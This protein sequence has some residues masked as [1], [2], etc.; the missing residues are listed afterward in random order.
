MRVKWKYIKGYGSLYKISKIG[1]VLS[2]QPKKIKPSKNPNYLYVQLTNK[3]GISKNKRI[4]RLVAEAFIPNPFN[5]PEVNH[6]DGNKL[7]N[8][9]NNLEWTT[10]KNN[11]IHMHNKSKGGLK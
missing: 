5:L 1:V 11:A 10:R 7:N 9:Y 2:F 6:K 4:H 8:C 3:L